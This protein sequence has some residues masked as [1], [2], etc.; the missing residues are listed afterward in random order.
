[1]LPPIRR[2]SI[3]SDEGILSQAV[4]D[5]KS[6][7][8]KSAR[9]RI[10]PDPVPSAK[11]DRRNMNITMHAPLRMTDILLRHGGDQTV[12][13][14]SARS[15]PQIMLETKAPL[16]E[17]VAVRCRKPAFDYLLKDSPQ[18]RAMLWT[19]FQSD[20][21]QRRDASNQA[22]A[23][24]SQPVSRLSAKKASSSSPLGRAQNDHGSPPMDWPSHVALVLSKYLRSSYS[25]VRTAFAEFDLDDSGSVDAEEFEDALRQLRIP[26]AVH[27]PE[28]EVSSILRS[29][30]DAFDSDGDGLLEFRELN[31]RLRSAQFTVQLNSKLK[32]GAVAMPNKEL[33]IRLRRQEEWKALERFKAMDINGDGE[34]DAEETLAFLLAEGYSTEFVQDLIIALDTNQDGKLSSDEWRAGVSVLKGSALLMAMTDPIQ[35]PSAETFDDLFC[36]MHID[37]AKGYHRSRHA[38]NMVECDEGMRL[39]HKAHGCKIEEPEKRAIRLPQLRAL[40][41]HIQRRCINE[42]WVDIE[43]CRLAPESATTYDIMAYVIKPVTRARKCSYVELVSNKAQ[44]PHWFASQWWGTPFQSFLSCLEQHARDRGLDLNATCY[45][46]CAYALSQWSIFEATPDPLQSSFL[47]AMRSGLGTITV[48]DRFAECFQR[49]WVVYEI[50]AT[51]RLQE[52]DASDYLW[53]V[54]TAYAHRL[55]GELIHHDGVHAFSPGKHLITRK[56][57]HVTSMLAAM[58]D[59]ESAGG[60]FHARRAVGITDGLVATDRNAYTKALRERQ[61]PVRLMRKAMAIVFQD[62]ET[63]IECDRFR[64]LNSVARALDDLDAPPPDCDFRYDELNATVRGAFAAGATCLVRGINEGGELLSDCLAALRDAKIRRFTVPFTDGGVADVDKLA[65]GRTVERVLDALPRLVETLSMQLPGLTCNLPAGKLRNLTR[66]TSLDLSGSTGLRELPED[67]LEMSEL[68]NLDLCRLNG[69]IELSPRL[70]ELPKLKRLNLMGCSQL[71][72]LGA[73]GVQKCPFL[74]VLILENCCELPA[75]PELLG[76][77]LVALRRIN[78]A[79]CGSL[80]DRPDWVS[81]MEGAGFSVV[82]PAHLRHF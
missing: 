51:V 54:Y 30:F 70:I 28:A 74:E 71:R 8:S 57:V 78:L 15:R 16:E 38:P 22:K 77:K 36:S 60:V 4:A 66:L 61:F 25:R 37:R 81:Q 50:A 40:A 42:S 73:M 44:P 20:I 24:P 62:G 18:N 34:A 48:V 53:D 29:V 31:K 35:P 32:A 14:F 68:T 43:N 5:S 69:L 46:S 10:G 21:T 82:W 76:L 6:A 33:A 80:S 52:Q 13:S 12:G 19:D 7:G 1:M 58:G 2:A 75:L 17:T 65:R 26:A 11:R 41:S 59:V 49:S 55:P 23:L 47:K 45:W 56:G 63:S 72:S 3:T 64:L 27:M 39:S 67:L 9:A 79:G